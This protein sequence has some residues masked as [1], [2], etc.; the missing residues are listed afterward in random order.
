VFCIYAIVFLNPEYFS[1]LG[2][3]FAAAG[4]ILAVIWFSASLYNQSQQ[5]KEQREQFLENF[6][7]LREDARMNA[8]DLAKDILSQA[9]ERALK[10]NPNLESIN[11]IMMQYIQCRPELESIFNSVDPNVILECVKNWHKKAGPA[12]VLMRGIKIAAET[13]FQAIGK[14]KVEYTKEPEK[15][16]MMY[17]PKLWKLPY[18]DAYESVAHWLSVLLI[19]TEP[20]RKAV[21][22][23]YLIA[24][25]KTMPGTT[26]KDEIIKD[27]EKHKEAGYRLP[28]IAKEF[29]QL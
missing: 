12:M 17:G 11:D 16:V 8:L 2:S 14:S 20:G 18:F 19:K 25:E 24:L 29:S 3:L 13:Y 22:I 23:A 28:A 7:Q 15:F 26:M 6:R 4:G 27:I 5:L 9:E 10:L 1:A 21:E